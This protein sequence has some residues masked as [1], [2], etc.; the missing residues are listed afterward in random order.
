ML[1]MIS[2][3]NFLFYDEWLNKLI[4][5]FDI[6]NTCCYFLGVFKIFYFDINLKYINIIGFK[7]YYVLFNK[8]TEQSKKKRLNLFY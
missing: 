3:F 4:N 7:Y 1:L 6:G 5:S 8:K 2:F